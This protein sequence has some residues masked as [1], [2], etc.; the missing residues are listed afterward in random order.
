MYIIT[1][2][3]REVEGR[4]EIT[5]VKR[6]IKIVLL[7][8]GRKQWKMAGNYQVKLQTLMIKTHVKNV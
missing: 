3:H 4:L 5:N 2:I 6:L 8:I 7:T 1:G